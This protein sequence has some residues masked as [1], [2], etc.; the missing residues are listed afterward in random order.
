MLMLRRS[1]A[2]LLCAVS[3][4]VGAEQTIFGDVDELRIGIMDHDT[5]LF[6]STVEKGADLNLEMLLKSPAWLKWAFS[7]RPN[8]GIMLNSESGT[9]ILYFGSS[10]QIPF[11]AG[12]FGEGNLALAFNDGE[13]NKGRT[14][15]R[16]MGC[17]V[18]FY[19]S[20][21]V[22]YKFLGHHQIMGIVDHASNSGFCPPNSGLTAVG[23]RYGYSF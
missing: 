20:I 16:N 10:W 19:E 9:N 3:T 11:G 5:D 17:A 7:P 2:A 15:K 21:S 22:G 4:C 6:S 18:G 14:D 8:M 23:A 13:K 1:V 12:F